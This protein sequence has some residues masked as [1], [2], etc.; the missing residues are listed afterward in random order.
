LALLEDALALPSS[1]VINAALSSAC[2]A[3]GLGMSVEFTTR[4]ITY[5]R[6]RPTMLSSSA[7]EPAYAATVVP[8]ELV[9]LNLADDLTIS[10]AD[11]H[12][13]PLATSG[14]NIELLLARTWPRRSPRLERGNSSSS[15]TATDDTRRTCWRSRPGPA[16]SRSACL[17]PVA[18]QSERRAK[19]RGHCR[20]QA[21]R[22]ASGFLVMDGGPA[23]PAG[24]GRCARE[25]RMRYEQATLWWEQGT[26]EAGPRLTGLGPALV[27]C[28]SLHTPPG[29]RRNLFHPGRLAMVSRTR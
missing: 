20:G 26:R 4:L 17:Q 13:P 24:V 18:G 7:G 11:R 27:G 10:P 25:H 22:A 3:R 5:S 15:T 28:W 19:Q 12:H 23:A 16:P 1:A 2:T 29:W 14:R 21:R 6:N 8:D 9:D